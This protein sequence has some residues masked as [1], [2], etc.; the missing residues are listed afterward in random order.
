MKRAHWII[1]ALLLTGTPAVAGEQVAGKA[2]TNLARDIQSKLR[3]DPDLKNNRIDV[4]VDN[5]VVTLKGTVDTQAERAKAESLA[6]VNGVVRVDDKLD[7]G[8]AGLKA[9]VTDTAVTGRLKA[10][11]LSED[12]LKH[13]D[14]SVTTNNGVVTLSGTVPS[15]AARKKAAEIAQTTDGVMRVANKLTVV[16]PGK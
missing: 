11:F 4:A 8:S 10:D 6:H 2:A 1:G 13:S 3:E 12:L 16:P 5:G 15:E 9:A 7:V 14:I